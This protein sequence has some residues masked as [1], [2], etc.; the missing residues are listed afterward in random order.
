[1]DLPGAACIAWRTSRR[2][3]L[4]RLPQEKRKLDIELSLNGSEGYEGIASI[5][6]AVTHAS[7][8]ATAAETG[9]YDQ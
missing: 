4:P 9:K 6:R 5:V 2:E 1:M 7:R 3:L 8:A